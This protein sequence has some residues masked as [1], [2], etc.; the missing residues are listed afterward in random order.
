MRWV[1]AAAAVEFT[2]IHLSS[3]TCEMCENVA[4]TAKLHE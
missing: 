4:L 2:S 1:A 3:F